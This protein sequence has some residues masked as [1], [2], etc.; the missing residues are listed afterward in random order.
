MS[1][2]LARHVPDTPNAA[3][4]SQ[5]IS[6]KLTPTRDASRGLAP[7]SFQCPCHWYYRN[8]QLSSTLHASTFE[9]TMNNADFRSFLQQRSRRSDDDRLETAGATRPSA[10]G[11]RSRPSMPLAPR[12]VR[13]ASSKTAYA[14]DVDQKRGAGSSEGTSATVRTLRGAKLPKGYVDRAQARRDR[15]AG[16]QDTDQQTRIQALEEQHRLGHMDQATLL[17]L[18]QKIRG[19]TSPSNKLDDLRRRI[20][21]DSREGLNR[22]GSE[23][24]GHSADVALEEL[25]AREVVPVQREASS[26]QGSFAPRPVNGVKRSRND[27]LA[28]LRASRKAQEEQQGQN[29]GESFSKVGASSHA[30]APT[31]E[32]DDKGREILITVDENGSVKRKVRKAKLA[33]SSMGVELTGDLTPALPNT[34]KA[35]SQAQPD[36]ATSISSP[37][38]HQSDADDDDDIFANVGD[39]YDPLGA[40]TSTGKTSDSEAEDEEPRSSAAADSKSI[41]PQTGGV[42]SS[43]KAS[44]GMTRDY[45]G[46]SQ[47]KSP[48][49]SPA[50]P[51]KDPTILAAIKRAARVSGLQEREGT[52]QTAKKQSTAAERLLSNQDRDFEDMDLEFGASRAIDEEDVAQESSRTK[53]SDWKGHD[54]ELDTDKKDRGGASQRKRGQK[55][56]KGDK[57]SASDVLRV[58]NGRQR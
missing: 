55:K 57:N 48:E 11:S 43:G 56:R 19:S 34:N 52:E 10:L 51:F 12:S 18:V 30:G 21:T 13:G 15:E 53:F 23:A 17:S 54:A 58:M 49:P 32:V 37:A 9:G 6:A 42:I 47:N 29:L 41:I 40:G 8:W 3:H 14:H 50:A 46:T 33:P 35:V 7:Q 4:H 16:G 5:S 1:A 27:I 28:E 26:K 38:E 25:E 36:A 24:M 45:F 22:V 31:I 20:T 44:G 2:R 39:Y